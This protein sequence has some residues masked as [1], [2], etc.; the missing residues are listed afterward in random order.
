LVVG[1]VLTGTRP[2]RVARRP[3]IEQ[4]FDKPAAEA[5][6]AM[7]NSL[8]F[9]TERSLAL[10]ELDGCFPQGTLLDIG[11]GPGFLLKDIG[12]RYPALRLIGIDPGLDILASAGENL[13][14]VAVR[15]IPA[16]VEEMPFDDCSLDFIVSTGTLHH[17]ANPSQALVEIHRV[18]KPGGQILIMDLRRDCSRLFYALIIA[19]QYLMPSAIRRV[20][21]PV[22]SYWASYTINEIRRL[23]QG[24]PFESWQIK[25]GLGWVFVWGKKQ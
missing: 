7:G 16:R 19:A 4:E 10:K 8:I 14:G 17:W 2:M 24:S 21:G 9:N 5:Y 13:R 23:L 18:L 11:C 6:N 22:G 12:R 3:G 1:A 25:T 15:L 20:N